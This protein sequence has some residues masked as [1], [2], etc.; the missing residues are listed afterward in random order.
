MTNPKNRGLNDVNARET[1]ALAPLVALV[2]II[3][4]FPN[5]FLSRMTESAQAVVDRFNDGRMALNAL[6]PDATEP[7][8]SPRR[9]G[10]LDKGFP[11]NPEPAKPEAAPAEQALNQPGVRP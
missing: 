8:L 2:F 7:A 10:P 6:G 1:L 9:G 5:I 11:E 3:G 4:F